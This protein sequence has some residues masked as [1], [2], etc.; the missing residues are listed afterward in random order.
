MIELNVA[1]PLLSHFPVALLF[2]TPVCLIAWSHFQSPHWHGASLAT[3]TCGAIGATLAALSGPALI[4]HAKNPEIQAMLLPQHE[5]VGYLTVALAWIVVA[6]VAWAYRIADYRSDIPD[7]TRI[8][9]WPRFWAITLSAVSGAC[10]AY[11]AHLGAQMV[12][13]KLVGG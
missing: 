1:H 13:G 11:T 4:P 3:G 5:L 7:E 2:A 6:L 12:W 10:A 8:P 9:Y